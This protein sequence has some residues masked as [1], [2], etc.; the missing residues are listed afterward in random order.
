MGH[1]NLVVDASWGRG[2]VPGLVIRAFC[3]STLFVVSV[4]RGWAPAWLLV[5][6]V[7]GSWARLLL[8]LLLILLLLVNVGRGTDFVQDLRSG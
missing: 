3:G 8:L 4:F 2:S 6:I 5:G 1:V 7:V